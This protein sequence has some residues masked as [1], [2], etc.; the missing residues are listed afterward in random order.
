MVTNDV[1]LV[2]LPE[3]AGRLAVAVFTEDRA[4]SEA[5]KER[6]I[7]EIARAGFEAFRKPGRE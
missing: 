3:G 2:D 4:P 5:A 6:L 7:A 1:A